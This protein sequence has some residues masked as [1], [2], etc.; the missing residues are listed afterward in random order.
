MMKSN[1]CGCAKCSH[2]LCAQRVP[3]FSGLNEEELS[4]IADLI[5][6]RQYLKGEIIQL[7]GS[8][9]D[10]LVIINQ[11][12]VKAFRYT[13]EG[14]EQILHLFSDGDFFGENN[15]L[16]G[17]K[18]AYSAEALEQTYICMID[19]KDFQDL[20]RRSPEISLKII[21]ELC[22]RLDRLET[23]VQNMGTRSVEARIS[24]TLLEFSEK[25]GVK[26]DKGLMVT[27]PFSR[28]GFASYIGV[29]R[30]TVSRKLGLLQDAGIIEMIGNKK[31]LL[32]NEEALRKEIE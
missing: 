7:E 26:H 17:R 25:Y 27:L 31:I 9:L 5:K 3:I 24:S 13:Q 4:H 22:N 30:E 15:L 16:G 2:Q 14:K 32:L 20:I 23:A 21:N 11:G 8:D 12:K 29:A 18:A 28:E 1:S 19:R 10:S 6:R